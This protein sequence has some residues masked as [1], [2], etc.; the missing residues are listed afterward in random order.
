MLETRPINTY[1]FQQWHDSRCHYL[2]GFI[3]SMNIFPSRN[4]HGNTTATITTAINTPTYLHKA[5]YTSS[6]SIFLVRSLIEIK[7]K[8]PRMIFLSSV[9]VNMLI[10]YLQSNSFASRH[11]KVI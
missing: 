10:I 9:P 11:I 8:K 3:I 4:F 2:W 6:M 5:T 7:R 1:C